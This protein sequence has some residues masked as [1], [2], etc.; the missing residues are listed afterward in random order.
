MMDDNNKNIILNDVT[1]VDQ[2]VNNQKTVDANN[3][4]DNLNDNR[5]E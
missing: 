3:D 5:H 1:Y 2:K 4:S